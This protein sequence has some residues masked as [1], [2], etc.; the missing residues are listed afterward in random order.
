ML[1]YAIPS[2]PHHTF[3]LSYLLSSKP[4]TSAGRRLLM[5]LPAGMF[6]PLQT[7]Y[8]LHV[9]SRDPTLLRHLT[10]L[11]GAAGQPVTPAGTKGRQG[12][13]RQRHSQR[14]GSA[15]LS[16]HLT[17]H[18]PNMSWPHLPGS[19]I[20]EETSFSEVCFFGRKLLLLLHAVKL[21]RSTPRKCST[22]LLWA[23]AVESSVSSGKRPTGFI[24]PCSEAATSSSGTVGVISS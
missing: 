14:V 16:S 18:R 13:C 10:F 11:Y 3:L 4:S 1:Y 24:R 2:G 17:Q 8:L 7:T 19:C 20:P 15:S 6:S 5:L 22:A 21:L 12:A 23:Q 9:P